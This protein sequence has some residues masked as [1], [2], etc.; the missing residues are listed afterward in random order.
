[1]G[2]RRE[3]EVYRGVTGATDPGGVPADA[4]AALPAAL[5]PRAGSVGQVRAAEVATGREGDRR[6][7]P[8]GPECRR[9]MRRSSREIRPSTKFVNL[10]FE[11]RL[12]LSSAI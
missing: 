10:C 11:G 7:R 8:G 4:R 1:M 9:D 2:D 5:T 3:G 12:D 6:R